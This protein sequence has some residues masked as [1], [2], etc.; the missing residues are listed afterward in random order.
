MRELVKRT[1]VGGDVPVPALLRVWSDGSTE[2]LA[3]V[4]YV[5]E[6]LG[7][8]VT[9]TVAGVATAALG[10]NAVYYGVEWRH[11]GQVERVL[12][13]T[14]DFIRRNG[15]GVVELEGEGGEVPVAGA[16]LWVRVMPSVTGERVWVEYGGSGGEVWVE[17]YDG[18]GQRVWSGVSRGKEGVVGVDVR[19]WSSGVYVV[20]VRDG[21]QVRVEQVRVVR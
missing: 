10:W 7:S 20:V 5:Y 19:G 1:G 17:V 6:T 16:G 13:A 8:G 9:D 4:A 11:W 12:R 21:Q 15:G 14:V 2:G 3:Q 18:L